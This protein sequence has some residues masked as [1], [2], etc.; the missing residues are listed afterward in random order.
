MNPV[1]RGLLDKAQQSTEAAQSLLADNYADFSASRAYYAMFY[2]LEALLLTKNLSFSKHSAVIAAF[3]K[4]YI[5]SGVLD[6]RFHRAVIDAF[7]LR[8]AGDYGT[9]H[10]VSAELASQTIQN[11]RELIHA[12]SSHIEG[13][14]RPKGFTLVELAVSLVVI[15]LLI[16]LGVGMVGPLMTAIKVRESKENLGGAVESVNS[17]AA[18]NNRLPDNSTGNSYSFVNVAKNPKDAWGRDFIY[19]FDTNLFNATP[20]KD[21]ICGRRTTFIT[22]TDLNTGASIPNVAYAVFSQ[23]DDAAT[24]ST[25]SACP[26]TGTAISSGPRNAATTICADTANDL[27]RWVTLD[28]LRTKV[29]CQ[30]AQLR[31]VNNELPFGYATSPYASTVTADGG[32]PYSSGGKYRWC[33][34]GVAPAGNTLLFRSTANTAIPFSANCKTALQESSWIQSDALVISLATFAGNTD[35]T[36]IYAC[37]L[38]HTAAIDNRPTSGTNWSQYWKLIGTTATVTPTATWTSGTSYAPPPSTNS[39]TIYVRDNGDTT[40]TSLPNVDN[41]NFASKTFVLTINP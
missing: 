7:D 4:E 41:D 16:G 37:T 22:L 29:G 14:Q 17:W 8:N 31:I 32:V 39:F 20:N 24:S 10:A 23:G 3:G 21:T 30:G 35:S 15:G 2:A 11:A 40:V 25:F 34:E 9:M 1:I 38:S 6:A 36:N 28:E 18:G 26:P 33:I 27:V 5:K 19:L 13:L 12:V